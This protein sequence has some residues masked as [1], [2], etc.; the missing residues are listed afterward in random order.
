MN[1]DDERTLT[2][3]FGTPSAAEQ[4]RIIEEE[5]ERRMRKIEQ[6]RRM[7]LVFATLRLMEKDERARI[8]KQLLDVFGEEAGLK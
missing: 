2:A 1:P 8:L 7:D 3:P 6:M 4:R 5:V